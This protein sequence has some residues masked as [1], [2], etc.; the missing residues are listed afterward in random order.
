[1]KLA[2]IALIVACKLLSGF[3]ASGEVVEDEMPVQYHVVKYR[4]NGLANASQ[5]VKTNISASIA[6]SGKL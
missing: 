2:L 4:A 5:Q 3:D 1:M 6:A